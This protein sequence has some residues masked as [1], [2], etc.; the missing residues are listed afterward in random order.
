MRAMPMSSAHGSGR[1]R[2]VDY[3]SYPAGSDA[4][5]WHHDRR[6]DRL[7]T[8]AWA[9]V[10]GVAVSVPVVVSWAVGDVSTMPRASIPDYLAGPYH[11][12]ATPGRVALIAAAIALVA[13][14]A[15]LVRR[16][17]L[18]EFA[19][20]AWCYVALIA[21]AGAMG[22]F[23]LRGVT[24]GVGGANI[25]GGMRAFIGPV[26]IGGLLVLAVRLPPHTRPVP[27]A[28]PMPWTAAAALTTPALLA[29]FM[30][31][32]Q[33]PEPG[34][35]TPSQYASVQLGQTRSAVHKILGGG[36]ESDQSYVFPPAPRGQT[37]EYYEAPPIE[38][39]GTTALRTGS[40]TDTRSWCPKTAATTE[41]QGAPPGTRWRALQ[42]QLKQPDLG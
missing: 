6:V 32:P 37:C 19:S 40:P 38:P 41:R 5:L 33:S 12:G 4:D 30:L 39:R 31:L 9:A 17:F 34:V 16:Q 22:A 11:L 25:G 7:R 36:P 20:T 15:D 23:A 24:A 10:A 26:L 27:L 21:A 1:E 18:R 42:D 3:P 28:H 2:G 13:G 35:P 14:L 8:G 29:G